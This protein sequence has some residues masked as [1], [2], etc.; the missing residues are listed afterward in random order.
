MN[1][2]TNKQAETITAAPVR[3]RLIAFIY[4]LL[5]LI[6]ILFIATILAMIVIRG[7]VPAGNP[8]FQLYI[9]FIVPFIFYGWFWTHGGQTL[10][11]RAWKIRVEKEDGS[12]LTWGTALHRFVLVIL[13]FA[14]GL[15]WCFFD[16]QKR[17]LYDKLS[18]T[19]V[20]MVEKGYVPKL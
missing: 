2:M 3:R 4:D 14:Y 8:V 15:I 13:T 6:A 16:E 5:L 10:G 20:V 7:A 19:R 18:R 12:N 11:M 9:F 1:Q 17:A